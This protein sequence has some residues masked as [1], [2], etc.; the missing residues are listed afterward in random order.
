M[1]EIK[2][3]QIDGSKNKPILLDCFYKEDAAAKPIVI[4][5]HGFKGFKDWGHFNLVAQQFA[6]AGF[7]FIKFNF[8]HNG[9]T[10]IDPENFSDLE[11]F[12]NNNYIIELDDLKKVIDWSLSA[13]QLKNE[14][15]GSKLYLLGHSRGGGITILKAGE[16]E[17]V[18]KIVTWASVSEM[19]RNKQL[20]VE[21]WK[22][23]GVVY[24]KNARTK[25]NMPLYYQFYETIIANKERLNINHAVKRLRIPLFIVHGKA[26]K[27]VK[28]HDAEELLHSSK[29]GKLLMIDN[30]DHT[31]GVTHPFIEPLPEMAKE[32]IKKTIEFFK[33]SH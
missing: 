22:K 28:Y 6:E 17:R 15:D 30:G 4:F 18:K 16:D 32:V 2:N 11:A 27:A 20:T 13:A 25:Q 12:G 8:S 1:K 7:V 29:Q 3:L 21:T 23:D 19:N 33:N 9:T 5:S 31:F 10:P 24:A 26:D 14:S